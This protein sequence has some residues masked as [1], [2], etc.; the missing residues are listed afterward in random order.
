MIVVAM[1]WA[2]GAFA[3]PSDQSRAEFSRAQE[4]Y[5]QGNYSD[6]ARAFEAAYKLDADPAYLFNIAQAYRLA[7]DCEK[8]LAFFDRFRAEVPELPPVQAEQFEQFVREAKACAE[9]QKRI[10]LE[11]SGVLERRA[12]SR[13]WRIIGISLAATG[14]AIALGGGLY[15][16]HRGNELQDRR[17]ALCEPGCTWDATKEASAVRLASD[18]RRANALLIGSLSVGG[19]FVVGGVVAYLLHRDSGPETLAVVPTV[20]GAMISRSFSF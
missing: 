7:R 1:C 11:Q 17:E 6:A 18:G 20:D 2:A 16:S 8:S 14:S 5:S 19:V 9:D 10:R 12:R 4:L 3:A 15:F 13:R